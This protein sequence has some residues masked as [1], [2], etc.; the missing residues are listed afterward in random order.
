MISEF[1][2][3]PS[4]VSDASGEWIELFN[5]T[6]STV[7]L[8]GWVL[9][10]LV[11]DWHVINADLLVAPHSYLVLARNADA[12]VNGGV[13]AAY[14]YSSVTLANS[15]DAILLLAPDQSEID[16]IEWGGA[17]SLAITTGAS[18]ERANF[19]DPAQWLVAYTTWS[20]SLG[21]QGT[22][23]MGY[24]AP[25]ATPTATE[26][27]T[28]AQTPTATSTATPPESAATATATLT[29]FTGPPPRILIS[30]FLADPKA[31]SDGAGEWVELYN[32]TN[33]A[34]N[35]HGWVLAGSGSDYYLI[36]ADL[37]IPALGYAVMARNADPAT[38][39]G[40]VVQHVY[41][42]IALANQSDTLLLIAPDG[43]QVDQVVWGDVAGLPVTAGRSYERANDDDPAQWELAATVWSGSAGDW[44]TPG[45]HYVTPPTPTPTFTTTPLTPPTPTLTPFAGPPPQIL[46]S[47]FMADPK[48]VS[49][50][51]GEWIELYNADAI[52]VN[53]HGWVIADSN[54]QQHLIAD[55]LWLQP[56]AYLILTR[57]GDPGT[58][59]GVIADYIYSSITLANGDDDILLLAPNGA[60]VDAVAWGGDSP[61]AVR[62]GASNERT[63]LDSAVLWAVAHTP[64]PGSAGDVGTPG[65]G[66][67][68]PAPT[69]SATANATP[70][71]SITPTAT[72]FTGP[73]P[74]IVISEMLADPRAV[75][76]RDGEWIEL[77]N[78]D[79]VAVNL[80]G[81][82]LADLGSD[83]HVIDA[84]LTIQSGR[85]V[86]LARNGDFTAN[87]GVL[88]NYVYRGI[89]LANQADAILLLAP[90]NQEVDR[91][92]WGGDTG[93]KITPGASLE[94]RDLLA[95]NAWLSATVPWATSS[96]DVGSPGAAYTAPSATPTATFTPLPG[97]TA[98][99]TPTPASGS[100]PHILISEFM[101]DP[102]AVSD[103]DGEWIELYNPAAEVINLNGWVLVDLG[104]QRHVIHSD[105][106]IPAGG[107]V[108]LGRSS[109]P[110]TNG[111]VAVDYVYQGFTLANGDDEIILLAPDERESDR[112][113]WGGD[114]GL[115]VQAGV[116]LERTGPG[117]PAQ[118][119]NAWQPW[120]TSLG[121]FGTPGSAWQAP[122]VT[123]T[124]SATSTVA[125]GRW[126]LATAPGSLLID[127]VYFQGTDEEFIA[128]INV[129]PEVLALSGWSIGDASLA[130]GSE[131]MLDLPPEFR[132]G[133][134]E[135][136]VI[137]RN[138]LAFRQRWGRAAHAEVEAHDPD[139]P[140]LTAR[141]DLADGALALND[142]GDEVVLLNSANEI[143]DAVA[144]KNGAYAELGLTG[145]LQPPSGDSLQRVPD[146]RF[147]TVAEV[148]HRF[149]FAP[150]RPFEARGL[151]LAQFAIHPTLAENL[152][153]VWGS[154]GAQSNFSSGF[155]APPHYLLAAAS[156]QGL[157][158]VAV[159]DQS[160]TEPWRT[161]DAVLS[162]PAWSWQAA[163]GEQ[164][165]LYNANDEALDSPTALLAY[166]DAT[167]TPAQWRA[168]APLDATQLVAIGADALEVPGNLENLYKLWASAGRPL[169]PAGN[170]NP[171]LPGAVD[172]APRYTGLAVT[173]PDQASVLEAVAARRGWLTS[174][175]G[176]WLTMQA[177][178]ANGERLWMGSTLI[179]ANTLTLHITY[180]DRSNEVA[181]LAIWRNNQRV[182]QLEQL[183]VDGQW[184]TTLTAPPNSFFYA[185]ATQ[186]DGD[187]AVT[188]PIY[189]L[190]ATDGSVILN[191]VLPAPAADHNG[192]GLVDGEDEFIE[193]Y[194]PGAQPVSLEGWRLGDNR[195][196]EDPARRYTFPK[197]TTINGG[198]Y[199]L[200]W[201]KTSYINLNVDVDVV[202]LL[203]PD[204]SEADSIAWGDKPPRDRSIS[205]IPDGQSWR[206]DALVT[207]GQRNRLAGD[208]S[209]G[210]GN[211]SS[212]NDD[213]DDMSQWPGGISPTHGQA[214]GP[215]NSVAHAKLFGLKAF[216][217]F[218][219][220]V[221][222]PPGLFNQSIYVADP[223]PPPDGP[224][225]GIGINVYLR[226]G[227]FPSL[228]VGDLVHVRGV[229]TSFRGEMELQMERP[230]QIWRVGE[231]KLLLPLPVRP[232]EITESVEGRLVTFS[233]AVSG[234]QNDSIYLVDPADPLAEPV[235][236]VVRTSLNWKRPYVN[237]GEIWQ[238]TGIVSQMAYAAP[239]NGGYRVLVRVKG[240][241]VKQKR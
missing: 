102:K 199:L 80:R 109:D 95:T 215:L 229:L 142:S 55:D 185:V 93:L 116:S 64:W 20:G 38:N 174:A 35:L 79:S 155:T 198:Q 237:K 141:R 171:P 135:V 176:L 223:A 221:V 204:G 124:P 236:V 131:G 122:A 162:I 161:N 27:P 239:W 54:G 225:A 108:V 164:A 52:P 207:P 51:N 73:L 211:S 16:R 140:D 205:R 11:S 84:D 88:A 218:E 89:A 220:I 12:N 139:T 17:S 120:P 87:G 216:V 136:F 213:D 43:T 67:L 110:A 230:D 126:P 48:A 194:N 13:I 75:D 167:N 18:Y 83:Y 208:N 104:N 72:P 191:E 1:L 62:A 98:T 240:D 22:P 21:D 158:F 209:G 153:A 182:Q 49:D 129:G 113:T 70:V 81:W 212:S 210:S 224:I 23:G 172:A 203:R 197:G 192:D 151:P 8:R 159:A 121:D 14:Q 2:A 163:T 238:V 193:L 24:V 188:A 50:T 76:D 181:G 186:M 130:G 152:Q 26:L 150:P 202:R 114:S 196:D 86:V 33:T 9:A 241:L 65:S 133:A 5:P 175:P 94:K 146:A 138:G 34:V 149:L 235:R 100:L 107:Y 165:V 125:P 184:S 57:N 178:Q 15:A 112:V 219:A 228:Q 31:V 187:F 6:D 105:L 103:T 90:N 32:T 127:E 166:L 190:P 39:G 44:G 157:D 206:N 118:W 160:P 180:G 169:L 106:L 56:G 60:L 30:E 53:L 189:V 71:N 40:V 177:E 69:P 77:Y 97:A 154:L 233:G 74:H 96:G 123:P 28:P 144:Y 200:V 42:S 59:G 115:T 222:A 214:D 231:G 234:W 37:I 156:A 148:R 232:H 36:D 99:A 61:L 47:E 226:R 91:V 101:A 78:A 147:P 168:K 179:P 170:S 19:V 10:D 111:G 128:L 45:N 195:G 201:R 68:P 85:Y 41:R 143:S 4:T 3:D 82:I 145:V 63:T 134:G 227:D 183:P 173:A 29:P 58:N 66:Y 7:N 92:V 117:N 217:E 132:L 25:P 137:A 46:I 119:V